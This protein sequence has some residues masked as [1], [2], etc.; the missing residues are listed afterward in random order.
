MTN[1]ISRWI[2]MLQIYVN[3]E[4]IKRSLLIRNYICIFRE[5]TRGERRRT[6]VWLKRKAGVPLLGGL[7][8]GTSSE[9]LNSVRPRERE[10]EREM[11]LGLW[12][13]TLGIG[14][15]TLEVFILLSYCKYRN[16]LSRF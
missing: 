6:S 2:T 8:I 12:F 10:R 16:C 15:K 7:P 1:S 3:D 13:E 11:R 9:G 14:T 5:K 4:K